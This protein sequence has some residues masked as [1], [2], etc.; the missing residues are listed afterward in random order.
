M[1]GGKGVA[2]EAGVRGVG[3]K[4]LKS[5]SASKE[6]LLENLGLDK[7]VIQAL[8]AIPE[9]RRLGWVERIGIGMVVQGT[10]IWSMAICTW[11]QTIT[12]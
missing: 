7:D 12:F 4:G 6:A 5:L 3:G 10:L 9:V 8:R 2:N 1:S 11:S